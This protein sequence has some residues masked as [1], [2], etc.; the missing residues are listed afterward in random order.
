MNRCGVSVGFAGCSE[1]H[2]TPITAAY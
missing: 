2:G 1:I